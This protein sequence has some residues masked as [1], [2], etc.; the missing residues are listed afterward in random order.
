MDRYD[1]VPTPDAPAGAEIARGDVSISPANGQGRHAELGRS[2]GQVDHYADGLFAHRCEKPRR[3]P[4]AAARS[5]QAQREGCE[6]YFH[7]YMDPIAK[8][9]ALSESLRYMTMDSWEAGMQNWT[10][11][12]IDQF[13]KLRGYDPTPYLPVLAGRVV[14]SADLSDRFLWDFRRTIAD[15]FAERTLRH[16]GQAA[17]EGH[18]IYAE[19]EGVS[20]EIMKIRC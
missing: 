16:D 18:G 7:G 10:D 5:G 2:G 12:M 14:G 15:L 3:H 8:L 1:V 17:Q 6:E 13:K 4:R 9:G 19:A 20:M 11:D